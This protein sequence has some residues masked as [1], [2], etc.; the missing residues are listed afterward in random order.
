MQGWIL[1]LYPGNPGEI[2]VWLKLDDGT[3]TRLVDS[4]TPSMFVGADSAAD[5]EVPLKIVSPDL[6][7]TQVV[8]KYER[9]TDS[10]KSD[11]V[12]A[13]VRD[14][15]K[16]Q[17]VAGRIERLGPYAAHRLY[18]AD[19]PP[20]QSYLYEHDIFPLARCEVKQSGHRLQ[21]SLEDDVWAYD[22]AVPD[23]RWVDVDVDISKEWKVA[24]PTDRITSI[25]LKNG[26]DKAT[27]DGG[28][29]ADKLLGLV[30]AIHDADP[31]FVLTNDGDTFLLPY[32]VKRAEANGVADR[33]VLDRDGTVLKIPSK[34]GTSYFSYGRIHYKPSAMKLYGRLHIDVNASFAYTEAGFEGLFE[35]SRI[36]RMPIQ[37]ASRASIGKALSSLQFYHAS[38]MDLL[39]PWKPIIAEKF[40]DRWT[41]MV[42]DRGG[43][44][45]EP[46]VGLFEGVGE[47]DFSALYPNIMLKKN[48]SAETV[49]CPCCPDSPNRIPEL[50]WNVCEKKKGI[51][52]RA[53]KIIVEKRLRY[54]QL[55]KDAKSGEERERYDAR[56]S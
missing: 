34:G 20:A 50:G 55:K 32:L 31:D 16:V 42:A 45:F 19:V 2:V 18:N 44:I 1:D 3:A 6:L 25:I 26:D 15:K 54:K 56:Q 37:T 4:W 9:I 49:R 5:L 12:E 48:L 36:C 13:K 8:R 10:R 46:R 41:L 22:Y 51:V 30:K 43:F 14:A 7:W 24:R 11:V 29:E 40:K 35:L 28:S 52:P 33:L 17:Q 38:K 47:L 23:L 53:I 27:I 39:V 21:W